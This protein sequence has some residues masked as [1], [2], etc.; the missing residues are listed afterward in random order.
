MS[1]QHSDH[2]DLAEFVLGYLEDMGS[3]VAPP[4]FG[5]YDVL[6]PDILATR[7]GLEEYQ[8]IAFP[9]AAEEHVGEALHLS[10]SHPLVDTIAQ[11]IVTQPAN[12]RAYINGVRL[13]K[14][15]LAELAQK[16]FTFPNARLDA[17]PGAIE[18]SLL[19]HYVVFN[20]KVTFV[21]EEKQEQLTSVVFDLQA[22]HAIRDAAILRR[23]EVL[24]TQSEFADFPRGASALAGCF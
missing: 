10:V 23:L 20:F 11:T 17:V 18:C 16:T 8:R 22:G 15:G 9:S 19:H 13:D 2:F 1:E 14:H 3:I 5:V 21:S 24:D 4:A 7:L 6:M 12:A